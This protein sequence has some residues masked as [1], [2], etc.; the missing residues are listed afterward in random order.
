MSFMTRAMF[1]YQPP[2]TS[3]LLIKCQKIDLENDSQVPEGYTRTYSILPEISN[4]CDLYLQNYYYRETNIYAKF[5]TLTTREVAHSNRN[6]KAKIYRS[7]CK[8]NHYNLDMLMEK[9]TCD[10]IFDGNSSVCPICQHFSDIHSR[11]V[12]DIILRL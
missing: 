7:N 5:D 6:K 3:Y 11:N 12:P 9:P 10:R 8:L 1:S 2:F 4:I